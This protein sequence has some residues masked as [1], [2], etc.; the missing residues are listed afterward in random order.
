[1]TPQ[2]VLLDLRPEKRSHIQGR[3]ELISGFF[4]IL[5]RASLGRDDDPADFPGGLYN[6]RPGRVCIG[7]N[8]LKQFVV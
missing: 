4:A 2:Q 7:D 1:V 8:A 5:A 3:N 6:W